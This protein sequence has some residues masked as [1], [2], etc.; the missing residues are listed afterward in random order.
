MGSAMACR[1]LL[2]LAIAGLASAPGLAQDA[3]LVAEGAQV[4]KRCAA[5]HAVGPEARNRVGPNLTGVVGRAA[6]T[7]ADF[8]Y[9]DAMVA[10]GEDGLV[11]DEAKLSEYLTNPR[12]MVKGSTMAFVGL[13]SEEDRKAVIAYLEAEGGAE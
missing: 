10:A 1:N 7:E 6:G 11:W 12:A 8:T 3:D 9:S 4:F 5:C 2:A 13:K